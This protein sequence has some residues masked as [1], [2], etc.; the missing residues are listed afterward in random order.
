MHKNTKKTALHIPAAC[1]STSPSG[2]SM[3]HT[4]AV[5]ATALMSFL[6]HRFHSGC[7]NPN[8]QPKV[9]YI[10]IFIDN[11][12]PDAINKKNVS[13]GQSIPSPEEVTCRLKGTRN[14]WTEEQ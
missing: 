13:L 5:F 6:G 10:Q 7:A 14:L 1:R 4:A 11:E 3:L 9:F 12:C 2:L 8:K